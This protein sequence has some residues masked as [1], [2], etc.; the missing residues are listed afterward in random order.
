M[1]CNHDTINLNTSNNFVNILPHLHVC[2]QFINIV[3]TSITR[4]N[5]EMVLI[6]T[7]S[8][9]VNDLLDLFVKYPKFGAIGPMKLETNQQVLKTI[10]QRGEK[11]LN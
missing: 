3:Y 5:F 8:S 2:R 4:D 11:M 10:L 1:S 6:V 9:C 7:S